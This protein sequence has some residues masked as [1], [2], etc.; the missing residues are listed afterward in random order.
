MSRA[1]KTSYKFQEFDIFK[2]L[3]HYDIPYLEYG[4]NIG[5]Q[6]FSLK[7]C[8][9]CGGGGNHFGVNI[10]SKGWSC[11][12]C[13]EK[14]T[15]PKLVMELLK[16]EYPEA[17][18]IIKEFY[19]G[20]LEFIIKETGDEVIMPSGVIELSKSGGDYL[21]SRNFNPVYLRDKYKLKQTSSRSLLE[22]SGQKSDFRYRIIIPIYM[23]R[24]LVSY[25]GRDYTEKSEIRYKHV[26]IEACI[27][28][29]SSCLY[30]IDT[31]KDKCIIVEGITDVW[32]L[33]DGTIS[34][35]GIKHTKEQIRY[36][37]DKKLKKVVILFDS[38]KEEESTKL[39]KILSSF[40]PKVQ[41]AHLPKGD[42]GELSDM[43]AVKIKYELLET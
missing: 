29:P 28:P 7:E 27:V 26:F 33:G 5:T 13:G 34:L 36:I 43:E 24:K 18:D 4:K 38:G 22:H 8:P 15:A 19:D 40:I 39:A 20:D 35:Q 12:I 42:P 10:Q 9:F 25:T 11:W 37:I 14:G 30:N 31:V 3:D 23:N 2:F 17:M 32:R 6:W 41:V 21:R 1:N 16:I